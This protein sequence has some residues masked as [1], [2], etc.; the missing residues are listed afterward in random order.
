MR[1]YRKRGNFT[2][3]DEKVVLTLGISQ[4]TRLREWI[5]FSIASFLGFVAAPQGLNFNNRRH[6]WPHDTANPRLTMRTTMLCLSPR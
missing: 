3:G 5:D 1:L 6:V 4:S 2:G